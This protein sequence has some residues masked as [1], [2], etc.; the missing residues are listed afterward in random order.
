MEVEWVASFQVVTDSKAT[1]L[2]LEPS[3]I[4]AGP[5]LGGAVKLRHRHWPRLISGHGEMVGHH[6]PPA[7]VEK[8]LLRAS[9]VQEH[10]SVVMQGGS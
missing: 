9:L 3:S 2:P 8:G 5:S 4:R 10:D 7:R 6:K 1:S